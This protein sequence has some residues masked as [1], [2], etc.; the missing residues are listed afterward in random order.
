MFLF[1]KSLATKRLTL[2]LLLRNSLIF[3]HRSLETHLGGCMLL[4]TLQRLCQRRPK[5]PS[6][7][8]CKTFA[9]KDVNNQR[10]VKYIICLH[11]ISRSC[12]FY[13]W[14]YKSKIYFYLHSNRWC[15]FGIRDIYKGYTRNL[16]CTPQS[17]EGIPGWPVAFLEI[18]RQQ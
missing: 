3:S 4:Y 1:W 2:I 9:S 17:F 18:P 7:A 14:L 13:R 5:S 8:F 15:R 10:Y 16:Y 11:Q 12:E 6:N